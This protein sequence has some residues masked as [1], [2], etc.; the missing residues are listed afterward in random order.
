[1][2]RRR[3]DRALVRD[4]DGARDHHLGTWSREFRC[5]IV[6]SGPATATF[7]G[8]RTDL[9]IK[10][11]ESRLRVPGRRSW[12]EATPGAAEPIRQPAR[13]VGHRC[14]RSGRSELC[15][16]RPRRRTS[17]PPRDEEGLRAVTTGCTTATTRPATDRPTGSGSPRLRS[18]CAPAADRPRS[19]RPAGAAVSAAAGSGAAGS[20][21]AA[22]RGPAPP[23]CRPGPPTAAAGAGRR[24]SPR[25]TGSARCPCR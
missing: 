18:S 23:A 22:G 11:W 21:P 19:H 12:P 24:R 9:V 1:M 7:A 16:P 6:N 8:Q 15:S 3:Q 20:R 10:T 14:W 2:V 25:W 17:W 13:N 4:G 5:V